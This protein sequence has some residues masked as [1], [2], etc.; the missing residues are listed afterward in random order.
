MPEGNAAKLAK[1]FERIRMLCRQEVVLRPQSGLSLKLLLRSHD[2]ATQQA[3]RSSQGL[4]SSGS[5]PTQGAV[6]GIQLGDCI[7]AEH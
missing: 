6:D 2:R 3:R 4:R 5:M 7:G 1:I